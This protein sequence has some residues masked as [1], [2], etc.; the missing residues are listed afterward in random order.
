MPASGDLSV[1]PPL[2]LL[3]DVH[4]QERLYSSIVA[5]LFLIAA[6]LMVWLLIEKNLWPAYF[7]ISTVFL[8]FVSTAHLT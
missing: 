5:V 1:P 6:I 7:I 4:L 2:I 8:A 3:N